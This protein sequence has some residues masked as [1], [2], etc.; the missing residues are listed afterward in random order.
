MVYIITLLTLLSG[1]ISVFVFPGLEELF[2]WR[3]G[4]ISSRPC[5]ALNAATFDTVVSRAR[6][7][8]D[9]LPGRSL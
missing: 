6:G 9:L 5:S 4:A 1:F 8:R 3:G 7:V 2:I